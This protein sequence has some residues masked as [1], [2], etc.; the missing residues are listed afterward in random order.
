MNVIRSSNSGIDRIALATVR[1]GSD[2]RCSDYSHW[3]PRGEWSAALPGRHH[4]PRD[5]L[6]TGE[7]R[8]DLRDDRSGVSSNAG[9]EARALRHL[10]R[11]TDEEEARY[12]RSPSRLENRPGSID[13]VG[14]P[15]PRR[16]VTITSRPDDGTDL[17]ALT[18]REGRGGVIEGGQ[19]RH[20]VYTAKAQI[21]V[22]QITPR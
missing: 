6:D 7:G 9:H 11:A 3:H 14:H 5:R 8:D 19:T 10:P 20:E 21:P 17:A 16:V 22:G 4:P 2:S 12:W 13:G 1:K 15:K 18:I